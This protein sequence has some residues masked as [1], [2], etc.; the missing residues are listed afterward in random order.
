MTIKLIDKLP[1]T[2][3]RLKEVQLTL[4]QEI[5]E[6]LGAVVTSIVDEGSQ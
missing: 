1:F 4:Y 6:M 5:K 2:E 3:Q